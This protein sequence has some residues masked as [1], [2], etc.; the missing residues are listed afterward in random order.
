MITYDEVK[1][2]LTYIPETGKFYWNKTR[3]RCCLAGEEAGT[4]H[5][6]GYVRIGL[7][8]KYYSAHRLAWLYVTGSWPVNDLDHINRCRSDN[9]WCNLREATRQENCFNSPVRKNNSTGFKGVVPTRYGTFI[10]K[11]VVRGKT[12]HLGSFKTPKQ[13]HAAYVEYI[14]KHHGQF[15]RRY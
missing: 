7:L 14:E 9:R 5:R 11:T 3:G 2:H 8:G 4:L 12:V 6:L 13:A 10:A 1:T 15:A